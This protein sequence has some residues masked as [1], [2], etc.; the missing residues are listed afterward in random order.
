MTEEELSELEARAKEYWTPYADAK[1]YHEI[2]PRLAAAVREAWAL[3]AMG[4]GSANSLL[5]RQRDALTAER[6]A[7]R[8]ELDGCHAYAERV[9]LRAQ[10]TALREA[11]ALFGD[12][13]HG[14]GLQ[15]NAPCDC[16][17]ET[18]L[19]GDKP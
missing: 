10:I 3:A 5:M 13:L 6:D 1:V 18:V 8:A 17:F 9:E 7:L 14:C 15:D 16:G 12:H 11:L 2:V 19:R 4:P